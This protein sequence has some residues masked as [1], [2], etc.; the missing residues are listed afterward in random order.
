MLVAQ[1]RPHLLHRNPAPLDIVETTP[2]RE[3]SGQRVRNA[4]SAFVRA[5]ALGW[6]RR[7]LAN[8]LVCQYA[9][10]AVAPPGEDR[11]ARPPA[12]ERA[13]D[14]GMFERVI[15]DARA[16]VLRLLR[17]LAVPSRASPI[18]RLAI[19]S[20]TVVARPDGYGDFVYAP[21][22]LTSLRIQDRAA[23]L[24]IADY[25]NRPHEYRWL[26][27]CRSCGELSFTGELEHAGWCEPTPSQC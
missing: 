3:I 18:A 26:T 25:L 5:T 9:P 16:H 24:F 4:G 8:W 6:S 11:G 27:T 20:G 13:F 17:D 22:A 7:D 23:S 10:C 14:D 19:A 15:L 1:S 21:V 2:V 12:A